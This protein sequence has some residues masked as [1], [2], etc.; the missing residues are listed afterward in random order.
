MVYV[1]RIVSPA[2][3]DGTPASDLDGE[4]W[5]FSD[6]TLESATKRA[7]RRLDSTF[8]YSSRRR[9]EATSLSY[10]AAFASQADYKKAR[11]AAYDSGV[12]LS[13]V[14]RAVGR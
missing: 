14:V 11:D 2:F 1:F 7:E 10:I 8:M 6:L 5:T 9:V 3:P 4:E 13:E 12:R